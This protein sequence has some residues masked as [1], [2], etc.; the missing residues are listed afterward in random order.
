MPSEL[1]EWLL[2]RPTKPTNERAL[3]VS[4]SSPTLKSIKATFDDPNL[5]AN[6]GLILVSTLSEN[7]GLEKLIDEK[8][9][10]SGRVGGA[11]PGR[12]IL[13]LVHAMAAGAN[14][15]DHVDMLRSG[16]TQAV[17]GHK[18]MAPSTIGTFLRAFSFGHVRQLDSVIDT[19]LSRAWAMGAGPGNNRLVID[20]DSTI[21]EVHGTNKQ[22]ANFGY[23]KCRCY[24]PLLAVRAD[25]GEILHVR[26]RK[27]SANTARGVRQFIVE[28]IARVR[29]AGATGEIVIRFDSGYWSKATLIQ[30]EKL[31]VRYSMAIRAGTKGIKEI[32]EAIDEDV[33]SEI[34]YTPDGQA[35]VAETIYHNRRLVIRRT[36][37]IGKQAELWPNWRYFGFLTDLGGTTVEADQFQRN[38]AVIELSIRDLKDS[39]LEHL[40]SGDFSANGVWLSCAALA[41]NLLR[42][43]ALLGEITKVGTFVASQTMRTRFISIAA[44]LVNASGRLIL[45]GPKHW[46][47]AQQFITALSNLRVLTPATG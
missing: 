40:P 34:P 30:L 35:Q 42:W 25:T 32:I 3:I 23:T 2:T 9:S 37:L 47:W 1:V 15:I 45:R 36:R 27:G 41:H 10:L 44:R 21:C 11:N 7:L 46:P 8:V 16:S 14:F 12:K 39:A 6:A 28:T 31:D 18:V 38:R 26:L 24:H 19:A 20:I 33:W 22:G 5:V 43:S 17:L 29:R 13:T 4:V